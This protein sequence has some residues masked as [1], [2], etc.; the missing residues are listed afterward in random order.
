MNFPDESLFC[1]YCGS[2]FN[3]LNRKA[4]KT[5]DHLI[6]LSKGGANNVYNKRN[7]CNL[8]N[9]QKGG[10]YLQE[11]IKLV[12]Q[13]GAYNCNSEIKTENIKYIIDYVDTAGEK[14]FKHRNMYLYYKKVYFKIIK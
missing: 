14:I 3:P 12:E 6:P 10:M 11:W 2:K 9:S 7:C 4:Y 13:E 1:C 8:C 5:I